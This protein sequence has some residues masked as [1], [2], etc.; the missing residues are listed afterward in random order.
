MPVSGLRSSCASAAASG[1]SPAAASARGA[2]ASTA[3]RIAEAGAT[4]AAAR[5][6]RQAASRGREKS[7]LARPARARPVRRRAA[8]RRRAPPRFGLARPDELGAQRLGIDRREGF[9]IELEIRS[10]QRIGRRCGERLRHHRV[11]LAQIAGPRVLG[12]HA[13]G[14]VV[15]A[16]R[17]LAVR[18]AEAARGG[19]HQ[20][21]KARR[22]LAQRRD[23]EHEPAERAAQRR[24]QRVRLG[25]D[26]PRSRASAAAR[27]RSR[28]GGGPSSIQ[29]S[30]SRCAAGSRRSTSSRHTRGGAR[31]RI[32]SGA[33]DRVAQIARREAGCA[34]HLEKGPARAAAEG[35]HVAREAAAPAA[36]LAAHEQRNVGEPGIERAQQR[37][38]L[39]IAEPAREAS[40]RAHREPCA[41]RG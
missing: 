37:G 8:R 28:P 5:R 3:G 41:A 6:A 2:G 29:S 22:P 34:R 39:E 16:P 30:S 40:R 35:V 7:R 18:D 4:D 38:Q 14:V 10:R 20:T 11:E 19:F 24:S 13:Q 33:S 25:G 32:A 23:V 36:G 15:E 21:G 31:L 9:A 27:A 1:R 12:E 17:A 26:R